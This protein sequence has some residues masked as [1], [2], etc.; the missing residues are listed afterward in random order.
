MAPE[1]K[2]QY[3]IQSMRE[4]SKAR[5]VVDSFPLSC[6]NYPKVIDYLTERFGRDD[7]LLKVYVRELLRLVLN[8]A[9]NSSDVISISSL[10][11]KLETQLRALESLGV[12]QDKYAA[13]LYPLVE[14]CL[15]E[16]KNRRQTSRKKQSQEETPTA[17]GLFTG[18]M[19]PEVKKCGFCDKGYPSQE[20]FK[21]A[22]MALDD[23][24]KVKKIIFGVISDIEKAFVQLSVAPLTGIFS[25]SYGGSLAF[26]RIKKYRHRRVVFGVSS[27]SLYVDI[28]VTSV[29]TEDE[30]NVFICESVR[31]LSK[32]HFNLRDWRW[33]Q[34]DL[35]NSTTNSD[36]SVLGLSWWT[37]ADTL[38]VDVDNVVC[39]DTKVTKRVILSCA[40]RV[41]D[42][43]GFTCPVTVV[44]KLLLQMSWS[45]KL[46]WDDELPEEITKEF[47]RWSEQVV[48]LKKIKIP[49]CLVGTISDCKLAFHV[50]VDSSSYAYATVVFLCVDTIN[51][52]SVQ[53]VSAKSIGPADWY[54][55]GLTS[56][57]KVVRRT[58]WVVGFVCN[59]RRGNISMKHLNDKEL[60]TAEFS[61]FK[62]IKAE[63]YCAKSQTLK[64][65]SN[66]Q[67]FDDGLYRAVTKLLRRRDKKNFRLLVLLRG[68]HPAVVL[69]IKKVHEELSHAGVQMVM[70]NL[71]E[72]L[73]I[74]QARRTIR[75]VV[76]N[77][78]KCSRFDCTKI[79]TSPAPLPVDRIRSA[80]AFEVTGIDMAGPLYLR[81][82]EKSLIV[83]FT[84]AVY[85]ALHLELVPSF[86]T[87]SFLQSLRRFVARR[88]RPTII[89]TDN[90]LGF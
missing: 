22:R 90:G 24:N 13:M 81:K 36:V 11:D 50:F 63:T 68:D 69:L 64:Q 85:R 2:F 41:F 53:L 30:L 37:V 79:K 31:L 4:G 67:L 84:C 35:A 43:I 5:E 8:A 62:L 70:C 15:P 23:E 57:W 7:I 38:T 46:G 74:P 29:N 47:H 42:P 49:R 26:E 77:C 60:R 34:D 65:L 19:K 56:Y 86:S 21:V 1:D 89:Y 66:V 48:E 73:C 33:N 55:S 80:A 20:C 6:S 82:G 17:A 88:G 54:Y 78:T 18:S 40:H 44:S 58:A 87:E 25:G 71:R 76:V 14:S 32:G 75:K 28:C 16:E 59:S 9:Q 83:V 52:V 72:R 12:T 27:N 51:T 39:V 61:L 10:Y 45:L 3:L